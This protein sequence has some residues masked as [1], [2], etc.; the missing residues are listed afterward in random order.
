MLHTGEL[1]VGLQHLPRSTVLGLLSRP[2]QVYPVSQIA[3]RLFQKNF[4][5]T[6]S[7]SDLVRCSERQFARTRRRGSN[8][9]FITSGRCPALRP[10]RF[11]ELGNGRG[12]IYR[13][14]DYVDLVYFITGLCPAEVSVRGVERRFPNGNTGTMWA[15]GRIVFENG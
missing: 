10:P 1:E 11:H 3:N 6:S 9:S 12:S 5:R 13:G 4:E 15:N 8:G 14:C 7:E 2:F